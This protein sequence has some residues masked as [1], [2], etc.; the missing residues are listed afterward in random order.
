MTIHT[1]LMKAIQDDA[2]RAAERDRLLLEA[3]RAGKARRQRLAP[4]ARAGK[5]GV[6]ENITLDVYNASKQPGA[7]KVSK[8][9][10]LFQPEGQE[11]VVNEA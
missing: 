3:R 11:Q 8:H 7:A 5:M 1:Y 2:R 4:A 6:S 9:M 10:I